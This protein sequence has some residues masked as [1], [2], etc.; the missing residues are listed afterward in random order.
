MARGDSSIGIGAGGATDEDRFGYWVYVDDVDATLEQ[1]RGSGAVVVAEPEDQPWGERVA[2]PVTRTA[3][4]STS[5]RRS[6]SPRWSAAADP[7]PATS[8]RSSVRVGPGNGSA[9]APSSTARSATP[10]REHLDTAGEHHHDLQ[11]AAQQLG[12][13]PRRGEGPTEQPRRVVG[14]VGDAGD[15]RADLSEAVAVEAQ[16][17]AEV[18]LD[19]LGGGVMPRGRELERFAGR[20]SPH[21]VA[22]RA[23]VEHADRGAAARPTDWCTPTSRRARPRR[24]P[25]ARRRRRSCG[26][27]LRSWPSRRR[28]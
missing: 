4:S 27:G 10:G 25:P 6:D 24:W 12:V 21:G 5:A 15:L 14:F 26:G 16:R 23:R 8:A 13:L 9:F 19:R 28:R 20:D 22:Q 1:L 2:A 11:V 7:Q 17:V 3:T 18:G